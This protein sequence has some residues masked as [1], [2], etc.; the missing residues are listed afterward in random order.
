MDIPM[1]DD[2]SC[3]PMSHVLPIV[4]RSKS[5]QG[6]HIQKPVSYNKYY[7]YYGVCKVKKGVHPSPGG[8]YVHT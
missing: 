3:V 7:V 8:C 1:P 2:W 4:N 5:L 6:K